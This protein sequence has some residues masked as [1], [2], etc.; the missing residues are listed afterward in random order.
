MTNRQR[1]IKID[2]D[3]LCNV[4]NLLE[5]IIP[6]SFK[7]VYITLVSDRQII[8]L[9][10]RFLQKNHPT[11]VLCFRLGSTA[12]IIISVETAKKQ[13]KQQYHSV[14][15]EILYLIIHG[16]LH[17]SGYNDNTSKNYDKMKNEQDKIFSKIL[18]KTDAKRKKSGYS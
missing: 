16:I 5:K 2:F 3:Y 4:I 15:D 8:H 14:E 1:K 13:A 17:L 6:E 12:E 9:N 18:K 7:R 11:D 10:R